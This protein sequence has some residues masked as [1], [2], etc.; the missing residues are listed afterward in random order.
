[1]HA[2]LLCGEITFGDKQGG[3]AMVMDPANGRGEN[4]GARSYFSHFFRGPATSP[5]DFEQFVKAVLATFAVFT[6]FVFSNYLRD[7]LVLA[8][9]TG[10]FGW[11]VW[12][13]QWRFWGLFALMALLLRYTMGSAVH[14]TF[15]YVPVKKDGQPPKS[16]SQS[17]VLLFKDLLFLVAFGVIAMSIANAAKPNTGSV[18]VFM[19]RAMLFIA[20]GFAWSLLD[21][22]LRGLWALCRSDEGP[23]YFWLIWSALDLVQF[24][25]TYSR[26]RDQ[27]VVPHGDAGRFL[28]LV[29]VA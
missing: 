29:P 15:M 11:V 27:S 26:T 28:R 5:P 25:V 9:F 18:E 23:R 21:A 13:G 16:R 3:R 20:V 19:Q 6:G 12:F 22:A 4:N 7:D 24:L 17:V 8:E 2:R 1:L 10:W 14:L